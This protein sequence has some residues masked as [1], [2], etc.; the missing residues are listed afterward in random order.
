MK[1]LLQS[2]VL[3]MVIHLIAYSGIAYGESSNELKILQEQT[4]LLKN[5]QQ[6]IFRELKEI[7]DL[8]QGTR[9]APTAELRDIV[10]T[11]KGQPMKGSMTAALTLFEFSDYQ[12]PF[13]GTFFRETFPHINEEYIKTGKLR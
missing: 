7:K 6:G 3:A 8:L 1:S 13:C 11:I 9:G 10:L 5:G 4:E 2:A 12:C